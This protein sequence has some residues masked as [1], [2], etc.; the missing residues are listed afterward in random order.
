MAARSSLTRAMLFSKEF[1][2]GAKKIER[3]HLSVATTQTRGICLSLK[4]VV[5]PRDMALTDSTGFTRSLCS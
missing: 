3:F 2:A 4:V 1:L 5:A